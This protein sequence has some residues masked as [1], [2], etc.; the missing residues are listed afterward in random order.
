MEKQFYDYQEAADF[1][2]IKLETLR[3]AK[4]NKRVKSAKKIGRKVFFRLVE[5]ERY[6]AEH[7][8]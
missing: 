6:K 7:Q 8:C 5:L 4:A 2:N 3:V 1:L